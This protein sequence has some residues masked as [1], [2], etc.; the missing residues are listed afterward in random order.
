MS[1]SHEKEIRFVIKSNANKNDLKLGINSKPLNLKELNLKIV[2]HPRMADWKKENIRELLKG[3]KL[4]S[5]YSESE[6]RLRY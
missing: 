2:C 3:I 4:S 1:F 5:V 6:I